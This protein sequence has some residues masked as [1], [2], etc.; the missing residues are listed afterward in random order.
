LVS[1]LP[2][3]IMM[4]LQLNGSHFD[5]AIFRVFRMF[6]VLEL[7]NFVVAFTMLDDVYYKS[8][9]VLAAAGILA[10]IIWIGGATL[11]YIFEPDLFESVP[12][13]MYYTAV[14]LGGEWGVIDYNVPNKILTIIFC[15]VGIALFSIPVA[16]LFE[17][18]GD[19]L[20]DVSD[21]FEIEVLLQIGKDTEMQVFT[22]EELR[23]HHT[24]KQIKDKIM[25][26]SL[27]PTGHQDLV[28]KGRLL[29]DK[30]VVRHTELSHKCAVRLEVPKRAWELVQGK[31]GFANF[32]EQLSTYN[33]KR[34]PSL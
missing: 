26:F 24:I 19:T 33:P 18:F 8:K 12:N 30:E 14:F 9:D 11:F 10:L 3:Y 6:R 2:W 31:E 4:L 21:G 29:K 15:V 5:S 25:D 27:I 7:E 28:F 16:T 1:I 22:L 17:A 34:M 32:N 20:E 23:V 13:A